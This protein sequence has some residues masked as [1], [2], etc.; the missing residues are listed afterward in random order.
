MFDLIHII[1]YLFYL[2]VLIPVFIFGFYG[3]IILFYSKKDNNVFNKDNKSSLYFPYISVVIPTHNEEYIISKKIENIL[4]TKYPKDKMELIFVDDSTD[5]TSEIIKEHEKKI[6][7]IKLIKSAERMGYSP[8]MLKGCRAAKGEVIV[9][10]D[11]HS[12]FNDVTIYNLVRHFQNP[13]V[14]AVSSRS[15][16]MNLEDDLAKSE[17]LYNTLYN[18]M[19]TAETN[20]DSTFWFKGEASA[21]RSS[22]VKTIEECNASFDTTVALYSRKMGYKALFDPDVNFYEHAP[23]NS[24]DR[25]KQKTIRAANILNILIF[26]KDMLFKKEYGKFGMII[27]PFNLAMLVFSPLVI[28]MGLIFLG[29]LTIIDFTFSIYIWGLGVLVSLCLTLIYRPLIV[30]FFHFTYSLLKALYQIR[31]TKIEYDK[32][33]KIISTRRT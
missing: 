14:G 24:D 26:F 28:L 16:I 17:D 22:I 8:S 7:N 32:V 10:T 23:T 4:N 18:K 12:F 25:L 13:K 30:T 31:F 1:R 2:M 9:L 15:V 6:P 27:L 21:V 19:R 29:I 33:E 5:S 3:I 20:M 11:A